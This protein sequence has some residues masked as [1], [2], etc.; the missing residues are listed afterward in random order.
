MVILFSTPKSSSR[1]R[2]RKTALVADDSSP[3][4]SSI[5]TYKSTPSPIIPRPAL[6]PPTPTTTLPT[7]PVATPTNRPPPNLQLLRN[8][9]DVHLDSLVKEN[10]KIAYLGKIREF[11]E[12][13]DFVFP[14]ETDCRYC[15]DCDKLY[16][17]L[18]YQV[19]RDKRSLKGKKRGAVEK[20]N[21]VDYQ[22]VYDKYAMLTSVE[23]VRDPEDP[24][25]YDSINT[26][27]S[28]IRS[29]YA[30]QYENKSNSYRWDEINSPSV[31]V[32]FI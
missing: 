27:R 18:W 15:V 28:A 30:K 8:N 5:N 4:S 13:C 11:K 9:V 12:Y 1:S 25:G 24:L 22:A 17:F 23:D 31:Q 16:G 19:H 29:Y 3:S 26:Y 7:T 2:R 20:F 6:P 21:P 14:Y 32:S 10:T